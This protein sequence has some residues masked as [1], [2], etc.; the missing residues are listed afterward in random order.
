MKRLL[1]VAVLL[2][3]S[4]GITGCWDNSPPPGPLTFTIPMVPVK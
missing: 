2:I 1:I 4:L 3:L